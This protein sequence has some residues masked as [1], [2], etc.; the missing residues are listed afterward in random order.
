MLILAIV[1]LILSLVL[2][3][4]AGRFSA[5]QDTVKHHF[6]ESIFHQPGTTKKKFGFDW[7]WWYASSWKNKWMLDENGNVLIDPKTGKRVPRTTKFL[8]FKWQFVQ[9]YDAWHYYKMLK[10]GFNIIADVTAS[11]AAVFLFV[12]ASPSIVAWIIM[13][14]IYFIVQAIIWNFSFNS[15]YDNWLLKEDSILR[16]EN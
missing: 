9:I 2:L 10:I 14:I 7:N 8:F 5:I 11:V 3:F 1:F 6:T 16:I 13:A 15:H 12:A 4:F